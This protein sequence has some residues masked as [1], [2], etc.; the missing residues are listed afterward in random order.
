MKLYLLRHATAEDAAASD[1][2]REL[3]RD[4][5]EE[6]RI[7]G[8][9]LVAL[10]VKPDHILTSPLVRARQTAD[11][12]AKNKFGA[13]QVSDEL[14]NGERGELLALRLT[15]PSRCCWSVNTERPNMCCPGRREAGGFV[16][17]QGGQPPSGSPNCARAR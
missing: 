6:A 9:A 5:R 4:G 2:A 17:R 10:G 14:Q 7:A 12:V 13:H 8:Q 11:L 16:A 3:T 15:K 1:A